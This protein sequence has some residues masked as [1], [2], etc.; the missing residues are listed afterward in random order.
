LELHGESDRF[1]VRLTG[2]MRNAKSALKCGISFF[3]LAVALS[4]GHAL[5]AIPQPSS[6][7]RVYF[8]GD[9]LTGEG[10]ESGRPVRA[11]ALAVRGAAIVATGTDQEILKGWR[12][13]KTEVVDLHGHFVMPGF[14]DAHV[15]LASAGLEKLRIDLLGCKSLEEMQSR[16]RAAAG[17]AA[18]GAWLQGLGWDHTLWKTKQLPTRWDLDKVT[19]GHPAVFDRVDGHIAVANS[20]AFAAAGIGRNTSDP[21]GGKFDH[22][23]GGEL[24]GV[25]RETARALI[26]SHVPPL[27]PA[28]RRRALELATQDA[29]RHGVTSAQDFSTWNDFLVFEQMER[30]GALPLRISE[31]LTF[32]DPLDVLE[33]HRDAH[34]ADD[35]LLHTG[36]LK[37]FMDGSLGSRT[38]ALFAPYSD[39]PGNTGI[40]RFE[41]QKLDQMTVERARA[42]F[43]IGFHAIGDRAVGMALDA[44][45]AAE[46]AGYGKDL[47]FRIEHAQVLAPDQIQRFA[48]DG[49]VASMQPSHI[50]TDMNWAQQRIG[51]ERAKYSYTWKAFLDA[52]VPLAF[53][54]DYPTEPITPFRGLYA[55][56]TRKNEAG[57][58]EYFPEQKVTID[59]AIAAYTEGAAYAEFDEKTKGKLVPGYLADFVVLDR[60]ITRIQ[61]AE[62]LQTDVLRT[63]VGGKTVFEAK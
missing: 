14:N 27:T 41:Q 23:S 40:P 2:P 38:A 20:A 48:R 22:D 37:A 26:Y 47:R 42:G 21:A 29:V 58:K 57:T 18:P 7:D 50:L 32:D 5:P 8:H 34:P 53:G 13:P 54:T 59:E 10:L 60:D 49:V 17:N 19:A 45:E 12:G 35:P 15:H 55:A 44:F 28:E 30:A 33:K 62:I 43:Q 51:P 4:S 52:S 46:A 6:A 16:I 63:V 1:T 56:I 36:M 9:I 11:T 39:D 25:A 24:T 3:A 61:P 31:W